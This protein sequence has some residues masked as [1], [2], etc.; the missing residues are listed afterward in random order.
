MM[1]RKDQEAAPSL[2]QFPSARAQSKPFISGNAAPTRRRRGVF[3]WCARLVVVTVLLVILGAGA[4]LA[5]LAQGPVSSEQLR[6]QVE[7]QLSLLLG[8]GHAATIGEAKLAIGS[9]GL[10][11][12]DAK[13]VRILRD[14]TVN[15]GVANTIGV[16]L[17][18]MPL[19]SGEVQVES[20]DMRGAAIAITPF[21][22]TEL[23]N[24]EDPWPEVIN[25]SEGFVALREALSQLETAM[26][27]AGLERL[28]LSN[29]RLIGFDQLGLRSP[30]ATVTEMVVE[31]NVNFQ[32][33]LFIKA[34][35]QTR[36]RDWVLQGQWKPNPDDGGKVLALSIDGM[37][38]SDFWSIAAEAGPESQFGGSGA[39]SLTMN[40]PYGSDGSPGEPVMQIKAR[41]WTFVS[42][43]RPL[44]SLRR[45]EFN[46]R[47]LPQKNQIEL[48]DS[49]VEFETT[50]AELIGGLRYPAHEGE[51]GKRPRQ[52]QIAANS[53]LA[54]GYTGEQERLR[55]AAGITGTIETA[56]KSLKADTIQVLTPNGRVE[57]EGFIS[58]AA[59]KPHVGFQLAIPSMPINEFKQFWPAQLAP[60]SR[61][62]AREGIRGGT[63]KDAWV[64]AD[65]PP[66]LLG[67]GEAYEAEN[68]R[69]EVPVTGASVRTV[70][71]IPRIVE[72]KGKVDYSGRKAVVHLDS[73]KVDL[74]SKGTVQLSRSALDLGEFTDQ[75]ALAKLDLD[76]SG[77]ASALAQIGTIEPFKFTNRLKLKPSGLSGKANASVR[78]AF[79]LTNVVREGV[80][81]WDAKVR[82]S[83]VTSKSPIAGRKLAKA[84]VTISASP[85]GADVKG[86]AQLDGVT[87]RLA[88]SGDLNNAD[89]LSSKVTLKVTDEQ[90]RK[91]G[92]NTGKI[93]TG[94]ISVTINRTAQGNR[95][96]ADL[97]QARLNFPWI[98]WAKGKGIPA[99]ATFVQSAQ[100]GVTR[101]KD[102]SVKGSGFSMVGDLVLDKNGLRQA[103]MG[104][105]RLN[106]S[107]DLSVTVD[108]TK[109]GYAVKFN[110]RR[111]DGRA[112]IRSI[113]N[114]GD[115]GAGDTTQTIAVSGKLGRLDGFNGQRLTNVSVDFRQRG[116]A[117]QKAVM[118]SGRT[119]FA[120][121]QEAGGM[122]LKLTTGNAGLVLRFLDLYTK[123][124]GGSIEADLT[125]DRSSTFRGRVVANNFTLLNEPRLATL[126]A[127][128]RASA[129]T[130]DGDNIAVNLPAIR[131]DNVKVDEA[132]ADIE[133]GNGFLRIARG[134]IA[135][136]DASAAFEGT[137]YD[138][139]NRMNITGTYLPGRG[140]NRV[141]SKIPIIGLAFGK[142]KVNGLLGVTFR[143]AGRY[144]N[145]QLQVNPLSIIAPGVFRNIFKF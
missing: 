82:L 27:R 127:K 129:R 76:L 75:Q 71:S 46:L 67:R 39:V 143:L 77:P 32:E 53:M 68:L 72:A 73:G 9:T 59:F 40:A 13:D 41:D 145:P 135:G 108:R 138:R 116:S 51:I 83:N 2:R 141:V 97:K 79:S 105:L 54:Y 19:L 3:H 101:I 11:A 22:P 119:L 114:S 49:P 35:L 100:D 44:A 102:L 126:L 103:K 34:R 61:D 45:G 4:L 30:T 55:A 57:G 134:R 84:N 132:V 12:L 98:G 74:G 86:T 115:A 1:D 56:T 107:D 8:E 43:N 42:E 10:L 117:I 120:L 47:L 87:A 50:Q 7:G 23:F 124:R 48:E 112:L 111:Y 5:M 33:G 64:K 140:L 36:F 80:R 62:W 123:M 6:A 63:I 121:Q 69:A 18:A 95:I 93:I 60:K 110:A 31:K 91:L 130:R 20:V 139:N 70:G 21:L 78:A 94:P 92:I 58:F 65:F 17:K 28:A 88:L 144:G 16:K 118:R 131:S 26:D 52:F 128:P 66:G 137:V 24:S 133:K 15:L 25:F 142:G 106:E 113:M 99:K 90:R 37:D 104:R 38:L 81:D 14:D 136:G 96:E 29:A 85:G 89:T 122:N 109:G 125:R